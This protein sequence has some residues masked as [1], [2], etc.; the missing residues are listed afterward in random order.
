M[1]SIILLPLV[2][3]KSMKLIGDHFYTFIVDKNA[4]KKMVSQVVSAKFKVDCI[5]VKIVNVKPKIKVQRTKKGYYST[6]GVKKAI[7][8]VKTGQK[9]ALFEVGQTEEA[10][11]VRTAEGEEITKTKK[12]LLK[13][14]KVKVEKNI[15]SKEIGEAKTDIKRS[16]KQSQQEKKKGV[17]K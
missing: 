8:K 2:N 1:R 14:T 17:S 11:T 16:T 15:V 6:G 9:I 3:E 4:T 12:S 5:D 7:V 10:V 13:G